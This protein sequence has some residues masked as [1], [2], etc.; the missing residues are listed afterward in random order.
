MASRD[1]MEAPQVSILTPAFNAATTLPETLASVQR[2]TFTEFEVIVVD[3]GSSDN[4]AAIVEQ[5]GARDPRFRLIRQKNAG[6]A[7]ARNTGLGASRA[8]FIAPLDADDVWHPEKLMRQMHRFSDTTSKT[9]LVYSW[10][11][12]IDDTSKITDRRLDLDRFEGNVY[13]A[14]VLANFVGN[15]SVPL[16]RRDALMSIG[17]WDATLQAQKAQGCEDW[18]AYLRLAEIGDFVLA[19]GFLTGYRQTAGA[20]S[21]QIGAMARSHRLVLAEARV[22]HPNLP[23]ALFRWSLAAFDFYHFELL[24][25][26]GMRSASLLSLASCILRDPTWLTRP[27]TRRKLKA[28]AR[29]WLVRVGVKRKDTRPPPYPIGIPFCAADPEPVATCSEGRLADLRRAYVA[30]LAIAR[31]WASRE[32]ADASI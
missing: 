16:M 29:S 26:M 9:V 25:G 7:A 28:W 31:E 6:V 23:R 11:V 17:G 21:R 4:T 1:W 5:F 15:S 12:D 13:A 30:R 8:P 20:M 3:D 2:Q 32:N 19:P 24:C 27:S 22:R 10:S 14:L 18:R